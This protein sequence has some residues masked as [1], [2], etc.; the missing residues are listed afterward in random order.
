MG[1]A[2]DVGGGKGIC[3]VLSTVSKTNKLFQWLTQCE[4]PYCMGGI[5]FENDL[6]E[7]NKLVNKDIDFE[8]W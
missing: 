8:I 5:S 3:G 6:H 2:Q 4:A 7:T 1:G